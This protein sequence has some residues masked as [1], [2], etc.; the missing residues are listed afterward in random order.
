MKNLMRINFKDFQ[1]SKRMEILK[2]NSRMIL[3]NSFKKRLRNRQKMERI[4]DNIK[5]IN[6]GWKKIMSPSILVLLIYKFS[7]LL[8]S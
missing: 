1:R 8:L 4:K 6:K 7:K 3:M 5:I 2:E